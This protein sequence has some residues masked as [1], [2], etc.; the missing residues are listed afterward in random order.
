MLE[1]PHERNG[2]EFPTCAYII[3]CNA[4]NVNTLMTN[5]LNKSFGIVRNDSTE[6]LRGGSKGVAKALP[7][8]VQPVFTDKNN[9]FPRDFYKGAA[10]PRR[11]KSNAYGREKT[12]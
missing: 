10:T 8:G 11:G 9:M 1:I 5:I 7:V 4:P 6:A 3:P 2:E 12:R